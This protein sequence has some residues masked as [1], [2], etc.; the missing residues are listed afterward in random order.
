M[1]LWKSTDAN[2][3]APKFAT[4]LVMTTANTSQ[5][6]LLYGN[7]STGVFIANSAFGVFGVDPTE[8]T[9]ANNQANHAGH[10]GWVLRKT[11]MGG[12]ATITAGATNKSNVGNVYIT[13]TGGGT[14]NTS[15]NAQLFVNA[16]SNVVTTIVLNN[17]GMYET[18]PSATVTG[19][20]NV[21]IT[22]TM[23]GRANRNTVETLV[24]MGSMTGD[25]S[26]SANDDTIYADA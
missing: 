5:L 10:A 16:T 23:G 6:N 25:G 12:V 1:S 4:S 9:S 19:N 11:G 26:A 14:G 17:A 21:T 7:T 15:A 24:A 3:S 22:L 8:Q 2:T 13:F 18:T 20:A